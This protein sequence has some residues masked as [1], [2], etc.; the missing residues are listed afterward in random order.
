MATRF[1]DRW[2]SFLLA[3][4]AAMCLEQLYTIEW[5]FPYCASQQDGPAAAV[6]GMPFPDIQWG[7]ASSLEYDFM[8]LVYTL[9]VLA[10]LVLVWPLTRLLLRSFGVRRSGIRTTL[11]AI[12]LA[13]ALVMLAGIATLIGVGALRPTAAI[14]LYGQDT[15]FDLRPLRFRINDL[16]Y[17]CTPPRAPISPK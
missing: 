2:C 4:G 6:F 8:P 9:N 14:R 5:T 1:L 3:L 11:G 10:L 7:G 17:A 16:H 13:I 15:Y 12:G